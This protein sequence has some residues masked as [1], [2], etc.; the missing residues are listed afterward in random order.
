[1]GLRRGLS[2]NDRQR[3]IGMLE[4]AVMVTDVPVSFGVLRTLYEG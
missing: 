4:G 1:M 2:Q 3:A